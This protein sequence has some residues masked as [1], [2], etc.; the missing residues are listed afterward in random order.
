ML[1]ARIDNRY[2]HRQRK[3]IFHQREKWISH[4][5][6]TKGGIVTPSVYTALNCSVGCVCVSLRNFAG[7]EKKRNVDPHSCPAIGL[8]N[9]F[10]SEDSSFGD[11]LGEKKVRTPAID[12]AFLK[13]SR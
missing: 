2:A 10:L 12:R 9:F 11:G 4:C 3:R 13:L 5:A 8:L 6:P 7:E 1:E